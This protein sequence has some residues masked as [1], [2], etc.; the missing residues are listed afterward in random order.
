MTFIETRFNVVVAIYIGSGS[1]KL[2]IIAFPNR[3]RLLKYIYF[4][5]NMKNNSFSGSTTSIL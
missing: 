2:F 1:N 3:I 4:L 5:L